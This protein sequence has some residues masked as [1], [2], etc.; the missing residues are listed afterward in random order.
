MDILFVTARVLHV[1]LGV[2][3]A[4][5]MIFMAAFVVP[6]VRDAGPD[7][8]KVAAGLMRRRVTDVMPVA[9]VLTIL[10]GLYLYWRVSGGFGAAYMGSPVGMSYGI[11]AVAAFVALAFGLG[12]I[13]PSML[14]AAAISRQAAEAPEEDRAR[15]LGEAQAARARAAATG[16]VVAWLLVIAVVTMAVGR[17][18]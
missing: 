14:K 9:A 1:G 10:S 12:V 13:R 16:Q 11:G 5:A 3:W 18:V 6:S 8:A 2:F 17:Y 7:G 15:L 4:G